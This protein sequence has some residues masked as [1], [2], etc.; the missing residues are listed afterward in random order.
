VFRGALAPVRPRLSLTAQV[1]LALIAGLGLGLLI[2]TSGEPRLAA[3]GR[4]VEPLG[5][6]FVNGIRMTIIPLVVSSLICGIAAAPDAATIGRLGGRALA[7]MLVTVSFAAVLGVVVAP[8]IFAALPID[9]AATAALRATAGGVAEATAQRA[10]A[11]P[12][13]GQWLTDLV[14]VNPIKSAADGAMLPLIVFSVAFGIA[15]TRVDTSRR[16]ALVGTLE[17]VQDASLTLVRWVLRLAPLGVFG[18]A[19]PLAARLGVGA[20]GAL[21]SYIGVVTGLLLLLMLLFYPLAALLGGMPLRVFARAALPAQAMAFSGRSSLA[22]LPAMITAT[23]DTLA[24]PPQVAGFLVPLLTSTF[25]VG[26]GVGQ[27]VAAV[28]VAH[29]YGVT[30]T[31]AQLATM[32]LTTVVASFSVPGIPGGTIVAM[33]PVLMAAGVPIEGAGLLLGVDTIPDM[34][35]TT[36]N[37]T[38][39]MAAAVV[40][41]RRE[42]AAPAA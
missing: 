3:I 39:D 34:F 40:L 25:R 11:L 13:F 32:A 37:V 30:L 24:L 9:A 20:V 36:A 12:S 18:L 16:A 6:L 15:V 21:A 31:P 4:G 28:F 19:V 26:A 10:Q 42:Q 38:G 33:V 14:P 22:A 2:A 8:P 41:G 7:F 35:R 23:R 29:L 5:T 27:T 17:G 1:L